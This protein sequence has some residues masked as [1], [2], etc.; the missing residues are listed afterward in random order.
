MVLISTHPRGEIFVLFY[1]AATARLVN[2][3]LSLD[4]WDTPLPRTF[5][6]GPR[7]S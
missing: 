2:V 1:L 5:T 7:G 4:I 3:A 6:L